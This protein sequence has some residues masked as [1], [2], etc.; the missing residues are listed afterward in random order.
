[1]PTA[2]EIANHVAGTGVAPA[3]AAGWA[4]RRASGEWAR[5]AG[6]ATRVYFDLASLTKP[7]LAVATLASGVDLATPIGALVAQARGT[8][9]EEIPLELFLS[10]RAGLDAHRALF[11]PA[12]R[13]EPV[14][15]EGAL[16]AAARSRRPECA[17]APPPEGFAPIYSDMGY[18][19]A[20][21]ALARHVGAR[22]AGD[23]IR[24]LVLVPLG[25]EREVGTARQIEATGIDLR[26]H[27]APTELAPW[28]GGLVVG[29]VHDENAWVLSG[30]GGSG[31]AGMFGTIGGV[32][33]FAAAVLD[34]H[35]GILTPFGRALDVARLA[36]ERPGGSLRAGFD[37]KSLEG[38]SAGKRLGPRSFGHLGFTGTSVWIDPD[39]KVVV[40]L[41]TNRV[42]PTR[43]NTAIRAARPEAHD[44]LFERATSSNS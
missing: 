20:G 12:T 28:R 15:Y 23:A 31:H 11:E 37:G 18:L 26:V 9:S 25:I 7:M 43:E 3:V 24:T 38:S 6:G 27:S 1:M 33:S 8:P 34:A 40:S 13:G 5:E 2:R 42:N 10:H 4:A 41:L 39:A 36:R 19:L 17:G 16:V 35:D 22:D 29:R 32:L 44:A 30:D 14:S 21:E